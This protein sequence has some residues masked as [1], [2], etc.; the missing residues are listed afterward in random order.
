MPEQYH[1]VV[2]QWAVHQVLLTNQDYNGA[3][4]MR[5]EVEDTMETLR[6]QGSFDMD[7]EVGGLTV[8]G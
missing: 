5:R 4:A 7:M 6:L 1:D 8:F 2:A 3:Y